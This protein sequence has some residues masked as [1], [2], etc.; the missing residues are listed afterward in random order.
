[1]VIERTNYNQDKVSKVLAAVEKAQKLQDDRIKFGLDHVNLYV[2]DVE[3]DWLETWDDDEES[4]SSV[5]TN[6]VQVEKNGQTIVQLRQWFQQTYET[7]W[8][9]T[10]E[11]FSTKELKSVLFSFR[12]VEVQRAKLIDFGKDFSDHP[13]SLIVKIA[14]EDRH[15]INIVLQIR[16]TGNVAYLPKDL[17]LI[18][19]SASG[20]FLHQEQAG[21]ATNLL[22]V[23][24]DGKQG[25]SFQVQVG[26]NDVS[27]TEYFVI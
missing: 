15:K 27:V 24:L 8:Q 23:E 25:E 10:E 5:E 26:L 19:V 2:E 20:E 21:D 18:L 13:I 22:S 3:G 1:M 11:V 12:N 14:E 7:G 17:Q 16:P 4:S 6:A 9:A